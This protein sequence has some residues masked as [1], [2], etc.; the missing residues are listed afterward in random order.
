VREKGQVVLDMR[1]EG[2]EGE[3]VKVVVV[4]EGVALEVQTT[5]SRL[6]AEHAIFRV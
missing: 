2:E 6:A 1:E 4:K 5:K 3:M